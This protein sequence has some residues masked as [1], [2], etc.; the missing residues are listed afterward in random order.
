MD[1]ES[2]S[3]IQLESFDKFNIWMTVLS[4]IGTVLLLLASIVCSFNVR[5]CRDMLRIY[6]HQETVRD[7]LWFGPQLGIAFL[8]RLFRM[9]LFVSFLGIILI[10]LAAILQASV[11]L[12]TLDSVPTDVRTRLQAVQLGGV[13]VFF[14]CVVTAWSVAAY[15]SCKLRRQANDPHNLEDILNGLS[16]IRQIEQERQD[17]GADPAQPTNEEDSSADSDLEAGVDIEQHSVVQTDA[18][19]VAINVI[20]SATTEDSSDS[21]SPR[22]VMAVAI[23]SNSFSAP[24]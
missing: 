11:L 8:A 17:A 16:Q 24:M 14:L 10:Y 19:A 21:G 18:Q 12:L 23:V 4:I 1:D 5:W 13:A 9:L 3:T 6:R 22:P 7:K 15:F 2:S 20:S